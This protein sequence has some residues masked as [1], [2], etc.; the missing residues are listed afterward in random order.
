[1]MKALVFD[2]NSAVLF[3]TPIWGIERKGR[4]HLCPS[5]A[6]EQRH[7][8]DLELPLMEEEKA[9]FEKSVEAT[10]SMVGATNLLERYTLP[11]ARTMARHCCYK[12]GERKP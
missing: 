3:G 2:E 6:R 5:C 9:R 11:L 4:V 8:K 10:K 1:M 12:E 7:R